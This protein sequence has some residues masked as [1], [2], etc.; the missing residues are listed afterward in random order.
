MSDVTNKVFA[1]LLTAALVG[2]GSGIVASGLVPTH[3]LE[4]D[5]YPIEVKGATAVASEPSEPAK[6]APIT[7]EEWAKADPAKGEEI[8]TKCQQCHNLNK[9]DPDKIGP[10]LYNVVGRPRGA[11]PGFAYSDAVKKLGGNW[12]PENI[13]EFIYKPSAYAPGT[14]MSFPGLPKAEDR[15]DVIAF[16]NTK[17]DAPENLKD[18][19]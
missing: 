1:A 18:A 12:T 8:A 10:D 11:E 14:K 15:A 3:K 9:G 2:M 4:K 7:T 6:P 17:S 19:K 13:A 16:L 5:A